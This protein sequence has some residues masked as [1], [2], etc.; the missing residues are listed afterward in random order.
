MYSFLSAF[1]SPWLK[2][3]LNVS[4]PRSLA[5][6]NIKRLLVLRGPAGCGKTTTI[7]SLSKSV[8]FDIVE[9]K[10]PSAAAD[11]TAKGYT[12]VGVQF[13]EFLGRADKFGG[14]AL[15]GAVDTAGGRGNRDTYTSQRRILLVE[16]FPTILS[17]NS[18]GLAAFRS[19]LQRYLTAAVS[20]LSKDSGRQ[21]SPPIVII[22]SETL[23]SSTSSISDNFTV[24]RL[25]GPDIYNNPDTTIIDFNSIAP[26][27]MYKALKLVLEKEARRSRRTRIPGPTVLERISEIGDIRS[28]ISSLE[29]LCLKG[30]T[31]GEWGGSLATKLKRVPRDSVALTSMEKESLEMITQREASLGIFHAVG[32]IVYNKREDASLAPEGAEVLPPPPDH[33]RQFYRPKISQ[34]SVNELVDETGTDIQTFICALHENYVPSCEGPSFTDCLDECIEALSDSD[35]LCADRRGAQ[36]SLAGVGVRATYFSAGVDMLRQDEI[37]FQVATRGLLFA[38]PHPVKRRLA[39]IDGQSRG[40]DAYKM[41]FPTSLRLWSES[42]KMEGL[43]DMWMKRSLGPFSRSILG[44]K[45]S[46]SIYKPGGVRSWRSHGVGDASL[47]NRE[48]SKDARAMAVTMVSRDDMLLHQLPY[49]AKI[50]SKKADREL[51]EVTG[52]RGIGA[53]S[54][55]MHDADLD[56]PENSVDN[57]H[58]SLPLRPRTL[59]KDQGSSNAFGPRLSPSVEEEEEKLILSDDD[60]E[61]D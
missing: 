5:D 1:S 15:D 13:E 10:N 43:V 12:S 45:G 30:D 44:Q 19:S 46:G 48:D 17:R 53:A 59:V 24:H 40:K 20:P 56:S 41:F 31:R 37:S 3:T 16:E 14:L 38:L 36:A 39:S 2:N 9:W 18:S 55:V 42:E 54:D 29:F 4:G 60:I 51:E 35:I 33:L 52:F 49:M 58:S 25:L 6:G 47:A 21:E 22:V 50:F 7:S 23:L 11:F 26:T 57:L 8:G 61:D 34:V 28:A 32:K 27:L